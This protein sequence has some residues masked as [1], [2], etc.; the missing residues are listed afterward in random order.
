MIRASR[1]L[2][3]GK[4]GIVFV[5]AWLIVLP[6]QGKNFGQNTAT[7]EFQKTLTLEGNQTVS[8]QHKFGDVHIHAENGREVRIAAT[9]RVQAHSQSEAD[10]FADQ[11]R[12]DVAQDSEGIKIQTVYPSEESKFFVVRVGG[13][14]YSVDYDIAVPNDTKLWT[15]NSFGN[16]E[17]SG[18][19][20]WA[21][22]ENGHGQLTF[23]DG[24]ST[25]LT[26]SFGAVEVNGAEG[27][28]AIVNNNGSVSVSTVK[29][30]LDIKDRFASITASNIQGSVTISGGNGA[31]TLTDA[32][33]AKISNS[34]GSVNARNIHGDLTVNDNNGAIDVTT[35]SG[36]AELNTSFGSIHFANVAGYVKCTSNNGR[37]QGGPAGSEVY[38]KTTFGEVSLEQING[39]VEVEDSNGAIRVKEIKGKGTFTTSFGAIE[40]SGLPK[41]VRATTGNGRIDLSDVGG[42]AYAKTSFG[43]VNVRRVNGNLTIE[44]SN[45]PV[46]ANAVKGD[47]QAKT[48]FGAVTLDDI[49]GSITVD[50]QNGT[51]SVSAART[52]PGCKN[53]SL[54]TSFSPMQVRV[55]A[56]AG[57]QL[58][59][60]TSFGHI[61]SELPVTSSGVLG[62]DSLSGKIGNGGCT[63][64]LT[65]SNG[66]IEILKLSK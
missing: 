50:N 40:A 4:I 60:R 5:T 31:V 7:R 32:G 21:D 42:D 2:R 9:I 18:V 8:L 24:G 36:E 20:G 17:I 37:V 44:N 65:N 28:V 1:S 58:S 45:G 55:P 34:F 47:A 11:V 25:K 26:N 63:L 52:S 16:V 14:S 22:V 53:I 6:A 46:T 49:T 39:P 10:R 57:F 51:V 19:H 62:G 54:K 27:S 59:A 3:V 33:S 64:S 56:D 30:T 48:S 66:N 43:A 41:G 38:V 15:K 12:I 61:S 23:R 13:P 35:V 29:D